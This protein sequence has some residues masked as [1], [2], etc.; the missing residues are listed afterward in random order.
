MRTVFIL[1]GIEIQEI[2]IFTSA[3]YLIKYAS[4]AV[5]SLK[6]FK[7]VL[8]LPVTFMLSLALHAL[9][10]GLENRKRNTVMGYEPTISYAESNV[11]SDNLFIS[12]I[13]Q[14]H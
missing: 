7:S 14:Q 5:D 13:Q 10:F 11:L 12:H 2:H 6:T 8:Y 3:F 9:Y 4:S 1:A